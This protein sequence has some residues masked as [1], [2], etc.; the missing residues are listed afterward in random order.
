MIGAVYIIYFSVWPSNWKPFWFI[1]NWNGKQ[2]HKRKRQRFSIVVVRFKNSVNEGI[3]SVFIAA[4]WTRA[5]GSCSSSLAGKVLVIVMG[6]GVCSCLCCR[7]QIPKLPGNEFP[8][9]S[10]IP[11]PPLPLPQHFPAGCSLFEAA[12]VSGKR[13]KHFLEHDVEPRASISQLRALTRM[14]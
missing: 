2:N 5:L 12:S 10:W 14:L 7:K 1:S 13:I 9:G 6:E 11:L 3:D 4:R 8:S